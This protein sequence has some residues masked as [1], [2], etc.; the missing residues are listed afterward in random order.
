[1]QF[2]R[3]ALVQQNFLAMNTDNAAYTSNTHIASQL[4]QHDVLPVMQQLRLTNGPANGGDNDDNEQNIGH[5][6]RIRTVDPRSFQTVSLMI[7][8]ATSGDTAEN[9][10]SEIVNM[11]DIPVC[12]RKWEESY[13][14]EAMGTER[15][16]G[17]GADCVCLAD[18][19]RKLREFLTPIE[20]HKAETTGVQ[21]KVAKPCLYCI[22]DACLTKCMECLVNGCDFSDAYLLQPHRNEVDVEGEYDL[23][24]SLPQVSSNLYPLMINIKGGY[25]TRIDPQT[26]ILELLQTGYTN[27]PPA[28]ATAATANSNDAA[29]FQQGALQVARKVEVRIATTEVSQQL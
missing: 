26:G 19:G 15:S 16:C 25:T 18:F 23:M 8:A 17:F 14:R 7:Q 29:G 22:R 6:A 4:F 13:L 24:D 9:T 21:D 1:M 5:P 2:N 11:I 20:A 3:F 10:H 12:S 27:P 28:K